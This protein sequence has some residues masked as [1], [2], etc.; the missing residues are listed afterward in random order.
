MSTAEKAERAWLVFRVATFQP[1][2]GT[3][4]IRFSPRTRVY[5]KEEAEALA[6]RAFEAGLTATGRKTDADG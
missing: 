4:A 2:S 5:G 6:R 1:L 3:A